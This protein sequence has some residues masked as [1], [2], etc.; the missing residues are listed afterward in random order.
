MSQSPVQDQRSDARTPPKAVLVLCNGYPSLHDPETGARLEARLRRIRR[1]LD[2]RVRVVAPLAGLVDRSATA[3]PELEKRDD[4]IIHRPA[5]LSALNGRS[6]TVTAFYQR[7]VNPF[8]KDLM[9]RRGP[10]DLIDAHGLGRETAAALAAAAPSGVPVLATEA[11]PLE[12]LADNLRSDPNH[13]RAQLSAATTIVGRTWASYSAL[14]AL[15]AGSPPAAFAPDGVDA[16]LFAEGPGRMRAKE[17]LE[18]PQEPTLLI[19]YADADLRGLATVAAALPETPHALIAA[20]APHETI[21]TARRDLQRA[22]L[23]DKVLLRVGGSEE[24]RAALFAAADIVVS[25]SAEAPAPLRAVEAALSGAYVVA[26]SSIA[27]RAMLGGADG[28]WLT[29]PNRDDPS[30]PSLPQALVAALSAAPSSQARSLDARAALGA[31]SD[32]STKDAALSALYTQ[33][34][35]L[36]M[37]HVDQDAPPLAAE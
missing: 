4:V 3:P 18:F 20:Q 22:G 1:L 33:A 27:A 14:A 35:G 26:P 31:A 25:V 5:Y 17:A 9:A 16:A 36:G 23:G 19:A 2:V 15:V 8:L 30:A 28:L 24:A 7:S 29:G 21:E 6:Q 12:I 32:W 11:D 34:L 13:V 37:P 10:F